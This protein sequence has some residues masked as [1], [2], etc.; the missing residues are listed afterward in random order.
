MPIGL[1][2]V[3]KTVLLNRFAEMAADD[4][5]DVAFI[6]A[7]EHSNFLSLLTAKLRKLLISYD[8]FLKAKQLAR[9]AL[10][11]LKSFSLTLPDGGPSVSIDVEPPRER[12]I[13]AFLPTTSRTSWLQRE[14]PFVPRER[15]YSLQSMRSS[16]SSRRNSARSSPA[17]TA[18]RR[19][20][21][22]SS[23]LVPGY[24]SCPV[25]LAR[26]SRMRSRLFDF[27]KIGSLQA[28]DAEKALSIPALEL[29]VKFNNNALVQMVKE[30]QVSG[31]SPGMGIPR[32]EHSQGNA[33]HAR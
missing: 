11:I 15:V 8:G 21:C 3:G 24:P 10:R 31:I 6:E 4:R 28:S 16:I 20:T 30:S 27:P 1:R 18:R 19:R 5:F 29:G 33:H 26:P 22:R 14:K 32:L 9:K 12:P 7:P 13:L 17:F 23:L 25:W 2:G